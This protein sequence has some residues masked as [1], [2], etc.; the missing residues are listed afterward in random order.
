VTVATC[1]MRCHGED[2]IAAMSW[3]ALRPCHGWHRDCDGINI[4]PGHQIGYGLDRSGGLVGQVGTTGLAWYGTPGAQRGA[5][6]PKVTGVVPWRL[7]P[8][9]RPASRSSIHRKSSV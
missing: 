8:A 6:R 5:L 1:Q 2:R 3:S 7:F 9:T 4:P